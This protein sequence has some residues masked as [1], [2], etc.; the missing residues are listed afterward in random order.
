MGF[1]IY[2]AGALRRSGES[3]PA[4]SLRAS[5]PPC[6]SI[7]CL[8]KARLSGCAESRVCSTPTAAPRRRPRWSSAWPACCAIARPDAAGAYARGPVGLAVRRLAIVDPAGGAQPM[9]DE[10]AGVA[11][12]FN[13]EIYNFRALRALLRTHGHRFAT[14]CDTE[15]VLRAYQHYGHQCV[16]HLRGMFAFAVWD[17]PRRQLLLARDR[18][19]I[20][21]LYYA[22]DGRTLVFG[23][24]LKALL[25][26][27]VSTA[28]E[29]TALDDFFTFNYI[30]A[31]RTI[32]RAVRKLPPAHTVSVTA[33]GAVE[34]EYW[35]LVFQPEESDAATCAARP[36][37]GAARDRGAARTARARGLH[38]RRR[39]LGALAALATE[40]R[41]PSRRQL[42]DGVRGA[43]VRRA[44]LRA[45]WPSAAARRTKRCV[46]TRW[47]WS[48]GSPGT[49][50]SRSPTPRWSTYH[51]CQ[52]ARTHV[53]VC[54]AGDGGDEIFAGYPR[55]RVPGA[56]DG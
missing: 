17:A 56:G 19:G 9:V 21:P 27:G 20:K 28:L 34:R 23:S 37:Q 24:E 35:D 42:L 4:G 11:V 7:F 12:A 29:A 8:I 48:T 25:E 3:S 32:Y 30:P 18:F 2:I 16:E 47:R 41:G 53:R 46:P 5:V 13:G 31:P 36:G 14:D 45:R 54:C 15:V 26:A 40:A 39:R 55:C 51:L 52:L 10:A 6:E 49:S 1:G 43:R 44:A 22:W 33:S 38:C 50:T